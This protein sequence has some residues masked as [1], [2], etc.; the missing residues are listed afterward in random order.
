MEN[1]DSLDHLMD[2]ILLLLT[3][4]Q[5]DDRLIIP[6]FKTISVILEKD[7]FQ[8]WDKIEHYTTLLYHATIKEID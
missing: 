4:H 7:E 5:K 1:Q 8:Q 3:T 6:L 2:Q